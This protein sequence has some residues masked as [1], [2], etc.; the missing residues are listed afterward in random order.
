[1]LNQLP[2][3][4]MHE[5]FSAGAI[6]AV[7]V[8][9]EFDLVGDYHFG[10]SVSGWGALAGKLNP[11]AKNAGAP[12]IYESFLRSL[13]LYAVYQ[14]KT[15]AALADL[16][17]H[18]PVDRFGILDFGAYAEIIEVGYRSAKEALANWQ[19]A[20]HNQPDSPRS[21]VAVELDRTL[22]TLD[23]LLALRA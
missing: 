5:L 20:G 15:T 9:P 11:F 18:P 4:I 13:S 8:A 7:D 17:I 3:D 10:S 23:A 22:E 19:E 14:A 16:Y 21:V 12:L 1:M 2:I 6:I